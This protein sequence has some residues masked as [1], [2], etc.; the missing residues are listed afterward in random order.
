VAAVLKRG[1]D[2]EK[3]HATDKKAEAV[4]SPGDAIRSIA[5]MAVADADRFYYS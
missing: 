5:Q 3:N 2:P 4:V 1:N